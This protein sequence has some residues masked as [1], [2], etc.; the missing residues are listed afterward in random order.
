VQATSERQEDWHLHVCRS[1]GWQLW[2]WVQAS[3]VAR[4]HTSPPMHSHAHWSCCT[5]TGRG[6]CPG[7]LCCCSGICCWCCTVHR[8]CLQQQT[9]VHIA[10]AYMP[11]TQC[12]LGKQ[13][14]LASHQWAG[15]AALW[16][17][18]ASF[19]TTPRL[20]ADPPF[21]HWQ[22]PSLQDLGEGQ[23]GQRERQGKR[24]LR[25]GSHKYAATWH[26]QVPWPVQAW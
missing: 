26:S 25:A 3:A 5:P 11:A 10:C 17:A 23:S 20:Q 2:P 13:H 16:H 14:K 19:A 7:S 18:A 24:P 15:R 8:F 12:R 21:T 9:T 6:R 1:A 22:T 4:P